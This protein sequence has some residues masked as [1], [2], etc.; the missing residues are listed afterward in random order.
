MGSKPGHRGRTYRAF[1]EW[2][3]EHAEYLRVLVVENGLQAAAALEELQSKYPCI[4]WTRNTVIGKLHRMQWMRNG[5][6]P[7][8]KVKRQPKASAPRSTPAQIAWN[9]KAKAE[10]QRLRLEQAGLRSDSDAG[11]ERRPYLGK[12]ATAEN[13]AERRLGYIPDI[14][15][16]LPRTS[17]PINET[18]R[19]DCKWPTTHDIRD[20]M[21]CGQPATAGAYCAKH[22]RLAYRVMPTVRRNANF[23]IAAAVPIA[24][25][26]CKIDRGE[27]DAQI[28]ADSVI[29]DIVEVL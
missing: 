22:A 25:G 26:I 1:K 17:R 15:E 13:I 3:P 16:A 29:D 11:L 8:P 4:A 18:S 5:E 7:K 28:I 24:L 14:V 9:E 6:V 21:V 20:F 27:D 2:D 12:R 10:R 23:R 19:H